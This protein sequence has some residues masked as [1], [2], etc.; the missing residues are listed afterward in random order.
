MPAV[1]AAL[2]LAGERV[3]ERRHRLFVSRIDEQALDMRDEVV[4]GCT[5][6][7]ELLGH[8]LVKL[9]HRIEKIGRRP[10]QIPARRR[11]PRRHQLP[12]L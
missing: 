8:D 6:H 9:G 11:S 7:W 10:K 2:R 1:R 4:A 12:N 3:I 5:L